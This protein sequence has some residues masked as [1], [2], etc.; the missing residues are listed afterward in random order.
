MRTAIL[1]Q[2]AATRIGERCKLSPENLKL[3]LDNGVTIPVALQKGGRLA[4]RLLYSIT[5]RAWFIVVQDADDGVILTVMPLEYLKLRLP[6]TA[7]Q[8]RSAR[9]RVLAFERT[10]LRWSARSTIS[11]PVPATAVENAA[12]PPPT[13]KQTSATNGWKIRVCY[14]AHCTILFKNLPKTLPAHG[15]PTHW[16][17]PGP[18]HSWLRERLIEAGIPFRSVEHVTAERQGLSESADCLLEHLPMTH[19]EIEACK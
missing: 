16:T 2:H 4:Q 12:M 5:D 9:S 3:L 17:T 7:A 13:I 19:E 14:T 11:T 1:T 18:V 6:V 15:D 10:R 8:R